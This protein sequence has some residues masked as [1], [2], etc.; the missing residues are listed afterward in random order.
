MYEN[1]IFYPLTI[2]SVK[3]QDDSLTDD[4][5]LDVVLLLR[6][7]YSGTESVKWNAIVSA[8]NECRVKWNKERKKDNSA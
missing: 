5:Y 6:S 4:Q 1:T 8:I 2:D 3:K 7:K